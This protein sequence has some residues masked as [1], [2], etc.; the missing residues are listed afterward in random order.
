MSSKVSFI[1]QF[2]N[3]FGRNAD[4]FKNKMVQI[5]R[6]VAKADAKMR[7]FGK[8]V[9]GVSQKMGKKLLKTGAVITAGVTAPILFMGR[10]MVNAASDATETANKF[11]QV[12]DTVE[13]KANKVADSFSKNFG[14]AGSTARKMIG[15]TGDL[16]TGFGFSGDAALEMSEKVAMLAAD[17]NSFQNF[18]GGA[19]GANIA[20]TKAILG[21]SESAKALGIVVRQG[22]PEFKKNVKQIMRAQRVNLLQA[23]SIEILRIA[24]SQSKKAVGDVARTWEDYAQVVRRTEEENKMMKES[25][26]RLLI[27]VA[28]VLM[29]KLTGVVKW[30]NNLSPAAKKTILVIAGIAAVVGP[31]ILLTGG[32]AFA[33][34]SI[35]AA[36]PLVAAGVTAM[37][38]A[39]GA[40]SLPVLAVGAAIA[41]IGGILFI[42]WKNWRSIINNMI[43]TINALLTPF[44]KLAGLFGFD[45]LQIKNIL[46]AEQAESVAGGKTATPTAPVGGGS[47][48]INGNILVSAEPGA[49][50]KSTSMESSGSGMNLGM[51]MAAAGA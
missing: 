34:T 8:T 25:F 43:N 41:A 23:K 35:V 30:L 27:P 47:G 38:I 21:E 26:G 12:F 1:I 5:E 33:L 29:N 48:T 16:L 40:L 49:Q 17:L 42:V 46:T 28:I 24:M 37:A 18:A 20:L 2:K 10:A 32:L 19:A 45:G 31:L 36:A 13:G 44:N 4:L 6:S 14:V 51:N 9:V 7:K 22:T 15:D 3:K 50:I 39:F 11:N